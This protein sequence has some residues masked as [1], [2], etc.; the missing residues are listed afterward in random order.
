MGSNSESIR[1]RAP[2]VF[3]SGPYKRDS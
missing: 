3:A 2:K 1:E